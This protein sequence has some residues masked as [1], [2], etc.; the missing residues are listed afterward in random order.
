[1]GVSVEGIAEIDQELNPA[2]SHGLVAWTTQD[3]DGQQA[4]SVPVFSFSF[5]SMAMKWASPTHD[6]C[7]S[8][9]GQTTMDQT[10]SGA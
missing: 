10:Q 4:N 1:M 2:L 9:L 3:G 6:A 8:R 5:V 7:L